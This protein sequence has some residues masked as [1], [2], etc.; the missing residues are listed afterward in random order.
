MAEVRRESRKVRY[1]RFLI[2]RSGQDTLFDLGDDDAV[3]KTSAFQRLKENGISARLAQRWILE[4]GEDYVL[5]K[6]DLVEEARRQ[7]RVRKTP[8]GYLSAAIKGDFK[9]PP[10]KTAPKVTVAAQPSD[11]NLAEARHQALQ[12]QEAEWR[13][14]CQKIISE[15]L[16][17]RSPTTRKALQDRF[18]RSLDDEFELGQFRRYGWEARALFSRIYRYWSAHLPDGLPDS[19]AS[20]LE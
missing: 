8:V 17:K 2:T 4:H 18:E 13:S 20:K 7:G 5:G 6:L 15:H 9:S 11:E 19:P 16:E 14:D 1:I 3:R 10:A 12:E